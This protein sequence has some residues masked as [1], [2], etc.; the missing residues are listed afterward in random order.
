MFEGLERNVTVQPEEEIKPAYEESAVWEEGA[1][2]ENTSS[3]VVGEEKEK[4]PLENSMRHYQ[5]KG[6]FILTS[7]KSGLMIINQQ[8]AHVRIL[9]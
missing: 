3:P 2:V 9:F 4:L 1:Q 8:R 7:V 6:S 5:Y